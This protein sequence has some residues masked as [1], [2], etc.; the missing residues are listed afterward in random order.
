MNSNPNIV[1]SPLGTTGAAVIP[2]TADG[3][4]RRWTIIGLLSLG[5]IIAY[6]SRSNL[7]V[8]LVMPDVLTSFH[9]SDTDR[10]A[11]NSAFFWAYA[12]LQ[13]PAGW[14]VDRYGVKW[15]YAL[16]FLFWC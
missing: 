15:P 16:G 10:G 2:T 5:I 12:A 14:V 4:G 11:L 3:S 9:L 6:L 7:S 13:L 8:A 1:S